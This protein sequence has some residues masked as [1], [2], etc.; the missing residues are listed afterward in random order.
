M[1]GLL[2]EFPHA[3]PV[4]IGGL[5]E[6]LAQLGAT[7]GLQSF[8]HGFEGGAL[9][10][11]LQGIVRPEVDFVGGVEP[12]ELVVIGGRLTEVSEELFEDLRHPVPTRAHIEGEPFGLEFPGAPAGLIVLFEDGHPQA[13]LRQIAGGR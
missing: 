9:G 10:G 2:Y 12:N 11:N 4:L 3:D 1:A 5:V 13:G 7:A 6:K 8:E